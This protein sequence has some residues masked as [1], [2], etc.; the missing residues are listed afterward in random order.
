M[1]ICLP[2]TLFFR[3][4]HSHII[5]LNKI[6]SYQKGR[7][8]YVTMEDGSFHRGGEPPPGELYAAIAE[9]M[10]LIFIG[11]YDEISFS[12]WGWSDM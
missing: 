5:N 8:G 7:G 11:S 3:I 2:E 9:I 12:C 10:Q 6:K 4:H 1:R